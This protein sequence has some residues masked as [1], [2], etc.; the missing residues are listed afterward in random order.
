MNYGT[1]QAADTYFAQR[2]HT[3]SWSNHALVDRQRALVSATDLLDRLAYIGTPVDLDQPLAFPRCIRLGDIDDII[4][5]PEPAVYELAFQLINGR[6]AQKEIESLQTLSLAF[7]GVRKGFERDFLPQHLLAGIPST[8]AWSYI[9]P[10]LREP[11]GFRI[12][13]VN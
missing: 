11:D 13:R 8:T 3:Q 9:R 5:F 4:N 1:V 7:V 6:D 10:Y 12:T 2:L